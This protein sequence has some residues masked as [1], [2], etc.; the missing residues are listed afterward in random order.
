LALCVARGIGIS[1]GP[2]CQSKH[3]TRARIVKPVSIF[4]AR[5]ECYE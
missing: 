2:N 5:Y 4:V 1:K 3:E